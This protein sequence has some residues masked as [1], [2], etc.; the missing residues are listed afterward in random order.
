MYFV[1]VWPTK[2]MKPEKFG[3]GRKMSLNHIDMKNAAKHLLKRFIVQIKL[4]IFIAYFAFSAQTYLV[5][6][7]IN[8]AP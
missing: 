6:Q 5:K 4:K 2:R 8:N 7:K 3:P 1:Y